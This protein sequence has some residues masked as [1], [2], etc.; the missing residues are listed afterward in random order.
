MDIAPAL[1]VEELSYTYPGGGRALDQVS[2]SLAAGERVAL[3]GAN[4]AGKSTLLWCLVGVLRASGKVVVG[5]TELARGAEAEVRRKLGLAFSEPDDQLFM[6]TVSRDLS[7][8]PL[9]AGDAPEE[10]LR[11]AHAAAGQVALAEDL[12]ARPPHEL[13]SGEKRR[14]ALA[15]VLALEPEVLA[16]DEPTNS[17]DAP[18]RAALA[19]ALLGLPC[20][21]LIATH[22]LDFV[23][24]LCPRSLVLVEGKLVAD[25][26]TASLLLDRGRLADYG[27]LA[28]EKGP[29]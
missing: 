23:R 12:L 10:S 21:Q 19:E 17:L 29:T 8:G 20:A 1:S 25:E 4:G 15:A 28:P 13:S 18:G 14:A 5:G 27:L 16:L 22:N 24:R 11:K 2:F 7:F 6:P 26:Q 9:A 3:L